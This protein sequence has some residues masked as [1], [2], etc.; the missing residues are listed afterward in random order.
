MG[1]KLNKITATPKEVEAIYGI[2]RGSLAN[3]RW[4]KRGPKYLKAG[5]RRVLYRIDDIEEWVSHNPV[6]TTDRVEEQRCIFLP[7][8]ESS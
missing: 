7:R 1:T 5:P 3:L 2:P 4:Q 6:L 8:S